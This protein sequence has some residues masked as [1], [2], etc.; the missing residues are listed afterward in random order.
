MSTNLLVV[1]I[2][3]RFGSVTHFLLALSKLF[4][5]A[6]KEAL[7]RLSCSGVWPKHLKKRLLLGVDRAFRALQ[8]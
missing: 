4:L 8:S 6:S 2:T 5:L 1:N 3:S 7:L